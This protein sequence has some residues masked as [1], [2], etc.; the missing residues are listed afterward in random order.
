MNDN[1]RLPE[2]TEDDVPQRERR[3][4]VTPELKSLDLRD[5]EG[6]AGGGTDTG[7]T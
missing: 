5:A 7:S 3:E 1:N 4:W 6:T 2:G